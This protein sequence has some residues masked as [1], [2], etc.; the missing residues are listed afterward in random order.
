[1]LTATLNACADLG[2]LVPDVRP[3]AAASVFVR[4]LLMGVFSR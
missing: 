2:W 3:S 1:M 4:P